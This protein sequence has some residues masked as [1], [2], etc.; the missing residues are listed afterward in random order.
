MKILII[1]D[2]DY[3]RKSITKV[4]GDNG[5]Q[6]DS[7]ENGALALEKVQAKPYDLIITDIMMPNMDGFEFMDNLREMKGDVSRTPVLA[8][9][10]GS[11][12]IDSDLAL[13]MINEKANGILQKPF[14][15][16]DLLDAIAKVIGK[17]KLGAMTSSA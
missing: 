17:S 5:F 3:I 10:G 9:S 13:K 2:V 11:K 14:S 8:I 1:D 4:L 16:S 15:K 12:T 7:C 6:C